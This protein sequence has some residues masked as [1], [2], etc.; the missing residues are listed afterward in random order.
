M[1]V[2]TGLSEVEQ[3]RGHRGERE[4]ERWGSTAEVQ[5]CQSARIIQLKQAF[6]LRKSLKIGLWSK[7]TQPLSTFQLGYFM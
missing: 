3:S 7:I 5:E 1:P 6:T 2:Y 4:R